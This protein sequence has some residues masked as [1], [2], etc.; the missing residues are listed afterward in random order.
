MELGLTDE[1]FGDLTIRQLFRH[2]VVGKR[3]QI[4]AHN[5]DVTLAWWGQVMEMASYVPNDKKGRRKAP[6]LRRFLRNDDGTSHG[7]A[8][9]PKQFRAK[10]LA[11]AAMYGGTVR[12]GGK[13]IMR[14]PQSKSRRKK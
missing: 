13:V 6:D 7:Q 9:T 12:Q 11:M 2:F 4:R 10:V 3:K 14:T 8:L 1:Q 5:R